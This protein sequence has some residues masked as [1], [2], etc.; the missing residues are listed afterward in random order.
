MDID[1]TKTVLDGK[2]EDDLINF[3][4]DMLDSNQDPLKHDDN[5]EDMDGEMQDEDAVNHEAYETNG[6]M[7]EDVEF[8]LHDVENPAHSPEHVDYEVSE[9][10]DLH[11]EESTLAVPPPDEGVY[12]SEDKVEVL[13]EIIVHG[14][15]VDDHESAHEIDYEFEDNAEPEELHRDVNTEAISHIPKSEADKAD[16]ITVKHDDRETEDNAAATEQEL[17]ENTEEKLTAS[18]DGR[19]EHYGPEE[20]EA[21]PD[22]QGAPG[23]DEAEDVN[24]DEH[25]VENT[26]SYE[27]N[28]QKHDEE[29]ATSH[30]ETAALVTG[31]NDETSEVF[32]G[33]EDHEFNVGKHNRD[34]HAVA[35]S[36]YADHPA[37]DEDLD[38]KVDGTFPAITVQYKGD[39]FPMFS[40]TTNGF[41]ADTSVLDEPLEKLLAGLRSELE[42][43]I[44][45]DDDLIL[46]VDE[47]GL[48]L[49]ETTQ[50]EL[51]SNVTLR[52]IHEIF[53][54]LV[55][56]QDPD[57]SR[58]LYAYLF[59]KHKTEKRFEYLIESATAG[60]GLDEV[61]HIFET[62]MTVGT[63]MLETAA[64]I[65]DVHEELDEFDSPVDD[66]HQG[67]V[68]EAEIE[69]EYPED[70]HANSDAPAS[71]SP[72]FKD[73]EVEGHEAD[74][75]DGLGTNDRDNFDDAT[76]THIEITPDASAVD[77]DPE[78]A[79][80][81]FTAA[82]EEGLEQDGKATPFSSGFLS[83]YYPDFCL[84]GPCVAE[85]VE[86]HNKDEADFRKALRGNCETIHSLSPETQFLVRRSKHSHSLS[87]F[88]TTYSFNKTDEFIPARADSEI[89]PFA[90]LE[91]DED[92]EFN[93]DVALRNNAD[94]KE[95][96]DV[97]AEPS[98]IGAQTN[99]TSTTTTLQ[100]E[101]EASTFHVDLGEDSTTVETAEKT[102]NDNVDLD[103]ID[104]R[105]EHEAEDPAP[106][107]PAT[108]GKRTRG[109]DEDVDAEDE[110]D[111]S[112][113]F[114]IVLDP[115][116]AELF[117]VNPYQRIL[118]QRD[119]MHFR[120]LW[121]RT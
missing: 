64:A 25:R 110:Q 35:D 53:D 80:D 82:D 120:I 94:T 78:A 95:E 100:E 3:D 66:E 70:E 91:L 75:H 32:G 88:S 39:E 38:G 12:D 81:T 86:S 74:G 106:T 102:K 46:Q 76:E 50:G 63:S 49:A 99:D 83:C 34:E 31:Q 43:E 92:A 9:A 119:L 101:E 26:H 59:T 69:D 114:V 55:K 65:D 41:F 5:F 4:T 68:N 10:L 37:I 62:P 16:S 73:H 67:E 51:M 85:Y 112:L 45:E 48:E 14:D 11:T 108:A 98:T 30:E 44:A 24:A 111:W 118:G 52:Q 57:G 61:I 84:C 109:D 89:D 54:L 60:K 40:T 107:T 36:N 77:L 56:N 1:V 103:E 96:V 22:E 18:H 72:E 13:K 105:D 7:S 79:M 113:A 42:N 116:V 104:W 33:A 29:H 23:G 58:T 19:D 115:I 47:L 27:E 28:D 6:I 121:D 20:A 2:I 97:G 87:D 117:L 17:S 15:V 8:D 71:E 93:G 21:E 90:N